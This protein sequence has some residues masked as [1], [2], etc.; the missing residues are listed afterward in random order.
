MSQRNA[1]PVRGTALTTQ[2]HIVK[3]HATPDDLAIAR[4][5]YI[6]Q[7][8]R[9]PACRHISFRCL[10]VRLDQLHRLIFDLER[11]IP[12]SDEILDEHEASHA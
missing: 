9:L 6:G 12:S 10:D 11:E 4:R 1:G 2:S 3:R 5:T 7:V 8:V